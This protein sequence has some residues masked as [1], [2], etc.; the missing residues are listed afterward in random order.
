MWIVLPLKA[1]NP[2]KS[3]LASV[4]SPDQRGFLMR[5]M[6]EDVLAALRACPQ[7][8][9]ILMV[10]RDPNVPALAAD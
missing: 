2:V 1:L 3:R 8:E 6:I 9:G 4:L 10:S 5:A 7:V